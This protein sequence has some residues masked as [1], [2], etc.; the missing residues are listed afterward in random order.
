MTAENS[1]PS[2]LFSEQAKGINLLLVNLHLISVLTISKYL[3][4]RGETEIVCSNSFLTID[5]SSLSG[6]T[7]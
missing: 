4:I 1:L 5:E 2:N 6:A 7:E 3:E